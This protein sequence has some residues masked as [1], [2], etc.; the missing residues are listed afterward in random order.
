VKL[1]WKDPQ[2]VGWRGKVSYRWLLLHRPQIGL[3]RLR[4]FENEEILADSGN[5]FDEE[6]KGGNAGVFSFDQEKVVW[7][8]LFYRCND[9]VPEVM[10]FMRELSLMSV[11]REVWEM[12]YLT[13]SFLYYVNFLLI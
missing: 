12:S 13:Q 5:I 11:G 10:Q 7:S 3:I 4:V 6:L 9:K 8:D 1:L 2:S